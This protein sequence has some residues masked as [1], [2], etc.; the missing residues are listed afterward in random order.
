MR[1][2]TIFSASCAVAIAALTALPAA[3]QERSLNFAI[4]GGVAAAPAYPGS[5]DYEAA[6]DLGFTFGALRFDRLSLGTGIGVIPDNG[7]GVRGAFRYIGER[8][9]ADYPV[10]S[11]L[12]DVDATLELGLGVI[13]RHTN[14]Q[15]FVDVRKGFGGHDGVTGTV[16]TDA[17]F[18][19]D[20]RWTIFA[21]PRIY[22][23][24][25][26]YSSTYF[27]V[28]PAEAAASS[29]S[30]FDADGG[31]LGAGF[32]VQAIYRL[33]DDWAAEGLVSYEKL[34]EDAGDS[35]ITAVG[36]E[37]QWRVRI[38]LS[39]AFTLRF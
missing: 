27:G 18:R 16:G 26:E 15:T 5:D 38:G 7:F 9:D 17:I 28:T 33:S 20:S 13:Y 11:G 37:D 23:G 29:F 25:S 8:D 34:V 2:S 30:A 12:N 36:S 10:L 32:D 24:D 21:G 6:P 4:R 3:A 39:R 1:L 14:F 31:V 22:L 35:P 19:P